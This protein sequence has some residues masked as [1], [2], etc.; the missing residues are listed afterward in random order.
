MTSS[1]VKTRSAQAAA[2]KAIDH[3]VEAGLEI[4]VQVVAYLDGVKVADA[5]GGVIDPASDQKVQPDTLFNVF[6]VTKAVTA[7]ALH[8]QAERGRIAYDDLVVKHWPEY[9]KHGKA[10]T[11]VRDI[12]SHRAGVPQMPPGMTPEKMCDWDYMVGQIADLTPIVEPGSTTTYLAMTFGWMVG[13]LVRRTD[14]AHRSLGTFVREELAE[15]LGIEDLW[16][17]LPDDAAPRAAPLFSAP[18][19]AAERPPLFYAAMPPEVALAPQVFGREDV[20]RAEVPAV[21]GVFNAQS[22]ARFWAMLAQGGALDGVRLLS[23]DRVETF[24]I[25]RVGSDEPDPVLL[26]SVLPIT[27]GGFWLGNPFP[28]RFAVREPTAICHPGA[29]NSLGWA[30][31]KRRLAV[32]YCHNRMQ[33]PLTPEED[34]VTIVADAIREALELS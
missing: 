6:S 1:A 12:L 30:D 10:K 27:I 19:S 3:V 33:S 21:G 23:A 31:F 22:S 4:G 18:A 28:G 32:G 20:R 15:P 9:G 5:C 25:P 7:T 17:G 26:N 24:N 14:P 16:I 29:G 8:I 11:T 13:E 34:P 2:Q